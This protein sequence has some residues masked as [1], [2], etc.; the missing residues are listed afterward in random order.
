MADNWEYVKAA[1][2]ISGREATLYANI[3][4]NII[5]VADCKTFTSKISKQ[6][7]EVKVLGYRG[8]QHKTTGW[9]GTGTMTLY[10]ISSVWS[11]IMLKYVKQG[12][13]TYFKLQCT[14]YDPTSSVGKQTVTL[15]DVNLDEDEIAKLDIESEGLE[16][17]TN[18]TFSDVDMPDEF[19]FNKI[20]I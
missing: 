7:K 20:N 2:I 5:P 11:K 16:K 12:I 15:I 3:D 18:F 8:T 1:D 4:G 19:D 13:D 17:T 14:N 10:H 9:S 6:K